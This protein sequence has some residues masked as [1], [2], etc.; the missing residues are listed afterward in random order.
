MLAD[1]LAKGTVTREDMLHL[2]N[3][4]QDLLFCY[5]F[6]SFSEWYVG[7]VLPSPLPSVEKHGANSIWVRFH[8]TLPNP[9]NKKTPKR[10]EDVVILTE[11]LEVE[12]YKTEWLLASPAQQ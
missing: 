2:F 7:K 8:K 5:Y 1:Q 3:E 6:E 10:H 9:K 12:A 11:K 4:C